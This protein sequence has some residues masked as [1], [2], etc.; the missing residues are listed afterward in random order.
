MS[1][2]FATQQL[3]S[4]EVYFE[5]LELDQVSRRTANFLRPPASNRIDVYVDEALVPPTGLYSKASIPFARPGPYKIRTN[6]N[7]LIYIRIGFESP[8]FVQLIPGSKVRAA[9]LAKHLQQ[10]IP[11]LVITAGDERV[12]FETLDPTGGTAFSFPDPRWTDTTSSLPTT[13]RTIAGFST[14]GITPGR[15]VRGRRIYPGWTIEDDPSSFIGEKYLRFAS[16]LPTNDPTI[17]VNYV[18]TAVNC[19][20]CHGSKFEFDYSILGDTY[21]EVRD[22]DLLAQEYDKFIFTKLGS[23]FKW[24]WLGSNLIDRIGSKSTP[25]T[26]ALVTVDVNQAFATYQSI[27]EQQDQQFPAQRVSDA[28]YPY[29]LGNLSVQI[30]PDDPTIAEVVAT[31]ITRSQDPV[32]F[33]RIVGNPSPFSLTGD[34]IQNLRLDPSWNFRK[35]G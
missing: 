13:V 9:D 15:Y 31:V 29:S 5:V 18:T 30:N 28:E 21:E 23:H 32:K 2:D 6:Q 24:Q 7:D 14:L 1:F 17:Q 26:A 34:P 8:R 10:Q 4:H 35:R 33:N 16:A 27:K 22:L 11:E 3:C 20:R 12:Y 19:R 25:N